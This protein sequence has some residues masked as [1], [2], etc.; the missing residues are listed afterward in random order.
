MKAFN[1]KDSEIPGTRSVLFGIP[2]CLFYSRL[3]FYR[4]LNKLIG[5]VLAVLC[6]LHRPKQSTLGKFQVNTNAQKSHL[7]VAYRNSTASVF[8]DSVWAF[9]EPSTGLIL[10]CLTYLANILGHK[11]LKPLEI[12]SSF[13]SQTSSIL[14]LQFQTNHNTTEDSHSIKMKL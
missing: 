2:V 13:A 9:I 3:L 6:K 5:Q 8:K 4:M 11:L 7:A 1:R 12:L 14:L 10:A